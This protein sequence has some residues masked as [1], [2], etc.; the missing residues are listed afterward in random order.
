MEIL[1]EY[2]SK[3]KDISNVKADGVT[4]NPSI[5]ADFVADKILH[6][7]QQNETGTIRIL[8]P[9][10]GEGELLIALLKKIKQPVEVFGYEIDLKTLNNARSRISTEFPSA[11]V[12]FYNRS[13]LDHVLDDFSG[14]LFGMATPYDIIIANPPYVRTQVLGV[15]RKHQLAEQF[16]LSGRVDLYHAFLI[17][18][19]QVLSPDGIAGF[20]VSNRFMSTKGGAVVRVAMRSEL[21]LVDVY[22]LGDTKIFDAAVL[23]AVLIAR[24]K[25]VPDSSVGFHSI[26]ETKNVANQE[27]CGPLKALDCVGDVLLPD[28]RSF[29]VQYGV[30]ESGDNLSGVWHLA[31]EGTEEWLNTVYSNTWGTFRD[32]GK[33][34][35]GVKTC[36]DKIFLPKKWE[37][38]L[39]LHRPLTTHHTARR[40][41][42]TPT[43][44]KILYPHEIANGCKTTVDLEKY[45]ISKAYLEAHRQTLEGRKYVI[46]AGRL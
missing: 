31:S 43:E 10:V 6:E 30:L 19:A 22:D 15:D 35:V 13:F 21:N 25:A 40:F 26:Y 45:P 44:R 36:A 24:G 42:S 18:M 34:R 1:K 23:P 27:A 46:D 2:S 41:R 9:A 3:L 12:H 16:G 20:I 38:E 5:L 37:E 14:G 8:D 17:G 39:E 11:I 7:A 4:Y 32:I 33:I 29:S 28:G